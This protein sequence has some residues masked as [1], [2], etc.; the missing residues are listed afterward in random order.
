MSKHTPGPWRISQDQPHVI[1]SDKLKGIAG[2]CAHLLY[3]EPKHPEDLANAERIVACVNACEGIENPA[4]FI[5]IARSVVSQ[6]NEMKADLAELLA[7]I[8][9]LKPGYSADEFAELASVYQ[10]VKGGQP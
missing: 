5:S 6:N 3:S 4:K 1:D 10:R 7:A 2:C 8:G 9:K